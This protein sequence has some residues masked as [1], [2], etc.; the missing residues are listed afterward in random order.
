MCQTDKKF[1]DI[2]SN[3]CSWCAAE[4]IK[5][6]DKLKQLFLEKKINKFTDV[7]NE[8]LF[9]GSNKRKQFND[10][11]YGENIDNKT[12]LEQ[13]N[14]AVIFTELFNPLSNPSINEINFILITDNHNFI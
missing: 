10:K 11:L 2:S 1:S 12:L 14:F 13:Y 5:K 3:Q 6:K 9:K 8:C 7:Y 4:F